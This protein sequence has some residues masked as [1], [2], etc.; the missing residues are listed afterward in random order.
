MERVFNSS[1]ICSFPYRQCVGIMVL[2]HDGLIW[3]GRRC[4]KN[5]IRE[6]VGFL[7]QMPQGG[8]DNQERPID[9]AYRELYEETGIKSVSFLQESFQYISYDFPEGIAKRNQYKGQTQ[10]WFAFRFEGDEKEICVNRELYGYKSEF[11]AWTWKLMKEIPDMVV[12][13][14]RSA[15]IKVFNEF[16]HLLA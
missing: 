12:D 14:K 10:K 13:F 16:I 4:I 9:A 7:W 15:Y 3:L 8:I 2:N 6:D 1:G 5:N 11:D